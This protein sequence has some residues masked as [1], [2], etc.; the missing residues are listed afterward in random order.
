MQALELNHEDLRI[1][2]LKGM[3]SRDAINLMEKLGVKVTLKGFGRVRRQSLLPGYK[4]GDD[5][6]I[7]LFLG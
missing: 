5:T 6:S 3:T 1:P 7:T 4:V 2:D